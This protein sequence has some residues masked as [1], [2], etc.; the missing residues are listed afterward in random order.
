MDHSPVFRTAP[1]FEGNERN[2]FIGAVRGLKNK[3]R[4]KI[5]EDLR[6]RASGRNFAPGVTRRDGGDERENSGATLRGAGTCSRIGRESAT[7]G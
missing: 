4:R 6:A 2:E 7:T 1:T 5:D 3:E